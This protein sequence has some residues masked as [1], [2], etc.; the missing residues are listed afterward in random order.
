MC[1]QPGIATLVVASVLSRIIQEW[2]TRLTRIINVILSV[3]KD[4][5]Q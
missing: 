3:A 4:R 1:D 5:R 2:L